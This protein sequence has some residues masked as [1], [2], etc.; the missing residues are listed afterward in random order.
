MPKGPKCQKDQS[1]KGPKGKRGKGPNS[2]RAKRQNPK[3]QKSKR[4]KGQQANTPTGQKGEMGTG[5]GCRSMG[6]GPKTLGFTVA[7]LNGDGPPLGVGLLACREG[8]WN[9]AS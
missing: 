4:A 2:K 5:G 8:G 9:G 7:A 6:R 3:S 1:A